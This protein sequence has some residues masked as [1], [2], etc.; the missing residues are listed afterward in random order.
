MTEVKICGLSSLETLDAA[1]QGGA[2]WVG[3]VFYRPSPRFV[4]L[5]LARRLADHA[6]G[7]A[8]IVA[9]GVDWTDDELG[10]V[11][12]LVKPDYLQAHG[13]ET[14]RRVQEMHEK[15]GIPVIKAICISKR[16]DVLAAQEHVS[17]A[18]LLL[19]DAKPMGGEMPGGNGRTFDWSLLEEAPMG[20][21]FMVSGGLHAGNVEQVIARVGPAV[22]DVSSGVE[23]ARGVKDPEL[24]RSFLQTVRRCG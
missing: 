23:R 20:R 16:E 5:K 1:L 8:K 24:I 6:R 9:L 7:K 2:H 15:T 10:A 3:L 13:M 12:T 17:S 19:Y 21:R 18:A 11:A 22:V 14:P 4:D